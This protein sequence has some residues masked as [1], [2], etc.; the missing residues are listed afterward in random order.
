MACFDLAA[1][2]APHEFPD[3]VAA[4]VEFD[5]TKVGGLDRWRAT[6]NED[7]GHE[8][9]YRVISA[10]EHVLFVPVKEL[11]RRLKISS[12]KDV[13]NASLHEPVLLGF[14]STSDRDARATSCERR[15]PRGLP[16]P[17]RTQAS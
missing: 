16:R 11:P 8:L 2:I 17:R 7:R 14:L 5:P 1:T 15:L 4:G 10:Y 9:A 6:P 12:T 3:S 13:Q